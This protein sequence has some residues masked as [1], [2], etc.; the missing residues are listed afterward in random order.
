[1]SRTKEEKIKIWDQ[2]AGLN[3]TGQMSFQNGVLK[4]LGNIAQIVTPQQLQAQNLEKT[5][6]NTPISQKVSVE[7]FENK[8][9]IQKDNIYMRRVVYGLIAVISVLIFVLNIKKI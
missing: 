1:M 5:A 8:V 9:S 3:P 2:I 7:G 6:T 4:S